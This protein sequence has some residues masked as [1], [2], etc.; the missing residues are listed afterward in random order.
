MRSEGGVHSYLFTYDSITR[1][2]LRRPKITLCFNAALEDYANG[3]YL[4]LSVFFIRIHVSELVSHLIT[5]LSYQERNLRNAMTFRAIGCP[6]DATCLPGPPGML[7]SVQVYGTYREHLVIGPIARSCCRSRLQVACKDQRSPQLDSKWKFKLKQGDLWGRHAVS[8]AESEH[9]SRACSSAS[10]TLL[11]CKANIMNSATPCPLHI[12]CM[13]YAQ[14]AFN[15]T[16]VKQSNALPLF[17]FKSA[18]ICSGCVVWLFLF[19]VISGS[20]V[21]AQCCCIYTMVIAVHYQILAHF[22]E[23]VDA[24]MTFCHYLLHYLF[25]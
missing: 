25:T 8:R 17:A 9:K 3:C 10:Q 23:I 19:I 12:I 18:R 1:I 7:I 22:K 11:Q 4:V 14:S 24:I 21:H 16:R 2:I 20:F 15:F 6:A 5:Q 13:S